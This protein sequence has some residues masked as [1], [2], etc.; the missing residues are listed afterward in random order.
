[1]SLDDA[2]YYEIYKIIYLF[3]MLNPW[4][5]NRGVWIIV[6]DKWRSCRSKPA[7]SNTGT[8][9]RS[10]LNLTGVYHIIEV[11]SRGDLG[12]NS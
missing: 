1:M 8:N 6:G 5:V 7:P 9:H 3:D 2:I 10:G 12:V 11:L 4:G